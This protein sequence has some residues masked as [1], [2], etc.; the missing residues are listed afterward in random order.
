MRTL[1]AQTMVL[2]FDGNSVIG[3]DRQSDPG[4]LIC[5]RHL[6]DRKRSQIVYV[7]EKTCFPSY[8]HN[9]S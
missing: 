1:K 7:S 3:A 2:I 5:L 9:M 8:V 6:L 4:Y